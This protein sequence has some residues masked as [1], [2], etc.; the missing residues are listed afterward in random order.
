MNRHI[1]TE[2]AGQCNNSLFKL[3]ELS[4]LLKNTHPGGLTEEVKG[5]INATV[6]KMEHLKK[7]LTRKVKSISRSRS[8]LKKAPKVVPDVHGILLLNKKLNKLLQQTSRE[9]KA[10]RGTGQR[11]R[12][13]SK[14]RSRSRGRGKPNKTINMSRS[15]SAEREHRLPVP[16]I[17]RAGDAPVDA[18]RIGD[19][20]RVRAR[21]S[22]TAT[23]GSQER[24]G[25]DT[26]KVLRRKKSAGR[27]EQSRKR[28][29]EQRYALRQEIRE[30]DNT[31]ENLESQ[32]TEQV[33]RV[34]LKI[35]ER[36]QRKQEVVGREL[37]TGSSNN[38]RI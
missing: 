28:L 19:L 15:S 12:K 23:T 22:S 6:T 17:E 18:V 3:N 1:V 34:Q 11:K 4:K 26:G 25:T 35:K 27:K 9:K 37:Q 33:R 21:R 10:V 8:E 5:L 13:T 20:E 2:H 29:A 16:Q 14:S 30:L 24:I 32:V 7:K 31:L 38:K 36:M